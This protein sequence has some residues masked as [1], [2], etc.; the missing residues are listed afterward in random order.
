M[1]L[2]GIFNRFNL[3]TASY[4]MFHC[5]QIKKRRNRKERLLEE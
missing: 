2:Y 5:R 1:L 4:G 3:I